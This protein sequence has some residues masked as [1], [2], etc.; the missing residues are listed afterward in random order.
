MTST[1]QSGQPTSQ[2]QGVDMKLEVVTLPVSDAD[3]AASA[4]WLSRTLGACRCAL[5]GTGCSGTRCASQ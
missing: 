1:D 4:P 3:R 2:T 5:G